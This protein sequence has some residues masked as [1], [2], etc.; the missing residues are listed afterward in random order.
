[1]TEIAI[2]SA[3]C[4]D[5]GCGS[6]CHWEDMIHPTEGMSA[7][8]WAALMSGLRVECQRCPNCKNGYRFSSLIRHKK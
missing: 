1:M 2:T 5:C 8:G 3:P 7:E 4:S 6:L